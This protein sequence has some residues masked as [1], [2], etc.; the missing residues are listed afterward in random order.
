MAYA[1]GIDMGG[2]KIAYGLV[3]HG[4]LVDK[5]IVP[6]DPKKDPSDVCKELAGEILAMLKEQKVLPYQV[7]G[8]GLLIPGHIEFDKGKVITC[9]N[10]PLWHDVY[11]GEMLERYLGIPVTVDND[12]N[13][14]AI[15]EYMFGAG[16]GNRHMIYITISTGIGGGIIINGH[17]FRGSYGTAGELGHNVVDKYSALVCGCGKRGCIEALASG[18][19]M[20]KRAKMMIENGAKSILSGDFTAADIQRAYENEDNVAVIVIEKAIDDLGIMFSNLYQTFNIRTFVV[21]GGVTKMGQWYLDAIKD[22][23][24]R[25]TP[26]MKEYPIVVT[27]AALGDDTAIYGAAASVLNEGI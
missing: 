3:K 24:Q 7:S 8:A 13:G 21:G 17:L 19:G 15:G 4:K 20:V 11:A 23:A 18:T 5:H 25:Y 27:A 9:S 10:M 6:S 22:A 12:A 26:M 14:A 16:R 2:T 1:I